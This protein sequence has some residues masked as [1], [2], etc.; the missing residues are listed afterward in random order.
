MLSNIDI[1]ELLA[2]HAER[3]TGVL[4]RPFRRAARSE[5][6]WPK[7]VSDLVAQNRSLTEVRSVGPF[8]EKQIHQWIEKP[9]HV[10]TVPSIRRDFLSLADARG[11]LAARPDWTKKLRGDLQMHTRWSYGSATVAEM[12]DAP[13]NRSYEYIAITDHSKALKIAGGMD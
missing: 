13:A 10:K 5:F 9:H 8:I 1:T 7:E 6:L 11:V 12:A 4:S 3:E 2:Q